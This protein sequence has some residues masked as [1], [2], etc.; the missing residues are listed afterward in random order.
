MGVRTNACASEIIYSNITEL[1]AGGHTFWQSL[2]Y[3]VRPLS[4]RK[5]NK[6]E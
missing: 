2:G 5:E 1:E 3:R 4:Q 6:L